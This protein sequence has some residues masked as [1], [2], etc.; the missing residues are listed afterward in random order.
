M[1]TATAPTIAQQPPPVPT[2]DPK[3]FIRVRTTLPHKPLPPNSARQPILTPRLILRP[4]CTNDLADLHELRT[5]PEVMVWTAVGV[6]DKDLDATRAS[7]ARNLPPNDG[8]SFNYAICDRESGKLIGIGGC[9]RLEGHFGW[10]E[11]GYMIRRE[12]WGKGLATEFLA[13]WLPAW[14][15]LERQEVEIVVD[16]RTVQRAEV[17]WEGEGGGKKVR[18]QLLAFTAVENGKSQRVL[19][20]NGFKWFVAW[21]DRNMADARAPGRLVDLST[22]R[23]FPGVGPE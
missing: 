8:E 5:Q 13:A 11:L 16:P 23:Y 19:E 4:L 15:G 18:E 6:P 10:P 20:K 22:Y 12:F 9:H 1:S 3:T 17:E 14:D 2:P 7:L 21:V